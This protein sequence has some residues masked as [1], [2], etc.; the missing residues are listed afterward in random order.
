MHMRA[1]LRLL[2]T[3]ALV[4]LAATPNQVAHAQS[5]VFLGDVNA[6]VTPP[7][8]FSAVAGAAGDFDGDGRVDAAYYDFRGQIRIA[9]HRGANSFRTE[10]ASAQMFGAAKLTAVDVMGDKRPEIVALQREFGRFHIYDYSATRGIRLASIMSLRATTDF[11]CGDVDG[12]GDVDIVVATRGQNRLFL[13]QANGTLV[14]GTSRLPV[15]ADDSASIALVDVDKDGDLDLYTGTRGGADRLWLNDGKG[16]FGIDASARLASSQRGSQT[17]AFGDVDGDGAL[18]LVRGSPTDLHLGD[19]RGGFRKDSSGRMPGWSGSSLRLADLDGDR[20]LDLLLTVAG[21]ANQL[22][23]ND[24][25]GFFKIESSTRLPADGRERTEVAMLADLDADADLDIFF[26]DTRQDWDPPLMQRIERNNGRGHFSRVSPTVR[27][28]LPSWKDR[29]HALVPFDVNRDGYEDLIVGRTG[30]QPNGILINDSFGSFAWAPTG[31]LPSFGD[32]TNGMQLAEIDGTPGPELV[33]INWSA[34]HVRILDWNG[35]RF[36]SASTMQLPRKNGNALAIADFDGDGDHDLA[37]GHYEA[38]NSLLINDGKGR[39]EDK[40]LT[41]LWPVFLGT[42]HLAA[43]DLEGDGDL[44]LIEC[45]ERSSALHLHVNDGKGSLAHY[46]R[47]GIAGG[48]FAITTASADFD[49]D[50]DTDIFVGTNLTHDVLLE[51]IASSGSYREHR[52]AK[53]R[54]HQSFGDWTRRSLV[55]DLDG[56]GALDIVTACDPAVHGSRG[57]SLYRNGQERAYLNSGSGSIATR[58]RSILLTTSIPSALVGTTTRALAV[59]DFDRDGDLDVFAGQ[60]DAE[61]A[62]YVNAHRQ[63]RVPADAVVGGSLVVETWSQ[64][65]DGRAES[66]VHALSLSAGTATAMIPGLGLLRLDPHSLISLGAKTSS[67]GTVTHGLPLPN[68]PKLRG[69]R[70]YLQALVQGRDAK[71]ALQFKLTSAA[72]E[73]IR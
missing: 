14:D 26:V 38:R 64:R 15:L 63:L 41:Q 58:F 42:I 29:A 5:T 71:G 44:D 59:S 52:L 70:I 57:G 27:K 69:A 6:T 67:S 36:V 46:R 8:E 65:W 68:D 53:P 4:F 18:D 43:V 51:R 73:V 22:W 39:F 23:I 9:F 24:G 30:G 20:D 40:T 62:L 1:L 3:P 31:I 66:F 7:L 34:P 32:H 35:A 33:Y 21:A 11:A 61:N 13:R 2:R 10:S 54:W 47:I 72:R 45:V 49:G 50:G 12:D 25:R 56:N 17:I 37:I 48:A 55:A 28:P 60:I 16:R 19:G